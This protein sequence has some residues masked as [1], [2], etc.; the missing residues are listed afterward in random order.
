MTATY[1]PVLSEG[2]VR[3][4]NTFGFLKMPGFFADQIGAISETFDALFEEQREDIFVNHTELHE[5]Q[6]RLILMNILDRSENLSWL[7]SD[8]RV[9]GVIGAVMPGAFEFANSDASIFDCE[10]SW[11][12]DTFGAPLKKLHVKLSLYLDPLSANTGAIRLIPGTNHYQSEFAK[13]MRNKLATRAEI[14]DEYGVLG[15]DIPSWSLESEP[16]DVVMWNYRT[17]HAS[18]YGGSDRRLMSFSYREILPDEP[19]AKS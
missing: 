2:Q 10:T 19:P 14:P 8:P 7:K 9:L 12:A 4:F 6:E 5:N 18:Y 17:V 11:H 13:D 3:F 15:E 1:A 16:G